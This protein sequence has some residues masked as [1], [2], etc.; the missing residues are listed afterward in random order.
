MPQGAGSGSAGEKIHAVVQMH[1]KV[2]SVAS[3]VVYLLRQFFTA[4]S[5][6]LSDLFEGLTKQT[7]R[8]ALFLAILE[9]TRHGRTYI[10]DD[11]TKIMLRQ[12]DALLSGRRQR[13]SAETAAAEA[14]D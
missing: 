14:Q 4:E 13:R 7:D 8:V 9:L 11:G 1:H 3:K 5:V 12:R 6:R 10:S 2:T